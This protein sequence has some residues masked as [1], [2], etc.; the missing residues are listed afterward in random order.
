MR[1]KNEEPK[2]RMLKTG[3][4]VAAVEAKEPAHVPAK[5]Q[6][7][8]EALIAQLRELNARSH[9]YSRRLWQLP[10]S[11]VGI[12]V[13]MIGLVDDTPLLPWFSLAAGIVG[14]LLLVH[15][16][17]LHDGVDR[18]VDAIQ[19]T[20]GSLGF[21]KPTAEKRHRLILWPLHSLVILVILGCLLLFILGL[22]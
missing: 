15:M 17:G 16:R 12:T 3:E 5:R 7:T 4:D 20:E 13:A 22:L 1:T 19:V 11:F 21:T 18:A 9:E 6:P 2:G 10:L 8:E 14:G